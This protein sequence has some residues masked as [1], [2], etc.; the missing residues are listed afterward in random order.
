MSYNYIIWTKLLEIYLKSIWYY[1]LSNSAG[2]YFTM[3]SVYTIQCTREGYGVSS[4]T[5]KSYVCLSL[6]VSCCAQ[7]RFQLDRRFLHADDDYYA[8]N[9]V[10]A[11][12][13]DVPPDNRQSLNRV[14]HLNECATISINVIGKY[15]SRD[16]SVYV[17]SQWDGVAM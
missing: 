6:S 9:L 8:S 12:H 10:I 13:N 5:S 2:L 14:D 1:A 7:H 16:H 3:L 15:P 17:P 11:L 4:V